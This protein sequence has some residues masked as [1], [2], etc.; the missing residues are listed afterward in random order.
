[1]T[2]QADFLTIPDIAGD[3]GS[4][5][6]YGV[7]HDE[8][9][10][11]FGLMPGPPLRRE[12]S[13]NVP[14]GQFKGT[15]FPDRASSAEKS[16]KENRKIVTNILR[17]FDNQDD[18]LTVLRVCRK[19][20]EWG[21]E[22]LWYRPKLSRH[23]SVQGMVRTLES[24]N[25]TL[26]YHKL[27]RRLNFVAPAPWIGDS[28]LTALSQCDLLERLTLHGSKRLS[29]PALE[30]TLTSWP[31]LISID[32][33]NV[34]EV[35][36]E[37][38]ILLAAVSNKLQG[39]NLNGCKI[40]GDPA[41]IA[42]AKNCPSLCR[43]RMGASDLV[44]DTGVSAI[45][46]GCPRL[47][48]LDLHRCQNITDIAVR[49]VWTH[50]HNMRQLDL[51]F[52]GS[53]T[54]LAFP[55]T[56]RVVEAGDAPRDQERDNAGLPGQGEH[57]AAKG[58]EVAYVEGRPVETDRPEVV[59]EVRELTSI[60][61]QEHIS[62]LPGLS[63]IGL[64][65]L[66]VHQT[67]E[68]LRI[69]DLSSCIQI[70]DNAIEGIT[71]C[72]PRLRNLVLS[73]C[74]LLTDRSIEA[75]CKLGRALHLLNLAHVGQVTDEAVKKLAQSCTRL[76]YVDFACCHK[77]TDESVVELSKLPKLRRIGLVRVSNITDVAIYA[78]AAQAASLER[79]HLSYCEQITLKA[80]HLL[81]DKALRLTHLSL[82][83]NPV[84]M[85]PELRRFIREPPK[86]L[87]AYQRS[88][89]CVYSGRGIEQLRKYLDATLGE[90]SD[91]QSLLST[92]GD[93]PPALAEVGSDSDS[94]Y[95]ADA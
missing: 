21:A 45:V 75:I 2:T 37:A 83:G 80:V 65:P 82:T 46:K 44:T 86:E 49:E 15:F 52:C 18:L 17:Y 13:D 40:P 84:F 43:L 34:A 4:D 57:D 85:V 1:M 68:S 93:A 26:A 22:L 9:A 11:N 64:C 78:L 30:A 69:L 48:E 19:W 54:D 62:S 71:S 29:A 5:S 51:A 77:L 66:T 61:P 56:I 92:I 59:P 12:L 79:T 53:L 3:F 28:T 42:L 58:R 7:T 10:S 39:V 95:E 76:R 81:L 72:A 73:K 50:A 33:T 94:D 25:P 8:Q 20:S 88:A 63:T 23:G 41:L 70:T 67:L 31:N 14:L 38:I 36:N 87:N 55:F 6:S 32:L 89:F 24:P 47:L 60:D 16:L 27:I 91:E 35:T 90:A 74:A